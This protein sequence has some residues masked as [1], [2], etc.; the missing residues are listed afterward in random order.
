[1]NQSIQSIQTS[2][3]AEVQDCFL[4]EEI[5]DLKVVLRIALEVS[6]YLEGEEQLT[7][8]ANSFDYQLD[9]VLSGIDSFA[10]LAS[11]YSV[12]IGALASDLD[13]DDM[14]G[15]SLKKAIAVLREKFLAEAEFNK[16]CRHLLDLFKLELALVATSYG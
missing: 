8:A 11:A 13:W 1:M 2:M 4:D 9:T 3:A 7:P 14:S 12:L 5:D 6:G 16:K 10:S 15:T